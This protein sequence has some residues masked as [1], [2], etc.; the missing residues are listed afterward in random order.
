MIMQQRSATQWLFAAYYAGTLGF[1]VLDYQFSF[2]VRLSFL[3][4]WPFWR[5]AYYVF[6]FACFLFIWRRPEWSNVTAAAESLVN[7]S[8]LILSMALKVTVLT[9][10]MVEQGRGA[11][12]VGEMLNFLISGSIAYLALVVHG[13]AAHAELSG[14]RDHRNFRGSGLSAIPGETDPKMRKKRRIA[15]KMSNRRAQRD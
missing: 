10:E 4:A 14:G 15:S 1:A 3:D 11:V 2:N 6:C 9:D 7:V 8:A 5:A 12:T 13:R